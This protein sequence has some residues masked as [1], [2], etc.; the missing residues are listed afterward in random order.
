MLGHDMVLIVDD[1]PAARVLL[2]AFVE[3]FGLEA[4]AAEDGIHALEILREH[5][6]GVGL[7][8]LDLAMPHLDGIEVCRQIK[9]SFGLAAPPVVAITARTDADA[10]TRARQVGFNDILPKP[11][12]PS[13]LRQIISLYMRV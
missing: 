8:L 6:E 1:D 7:V 4:V 10:Y 11:F 2:T 3:S 13:A 9:D 5:S 12:E